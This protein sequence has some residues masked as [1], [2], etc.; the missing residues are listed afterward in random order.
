V[1]FAVVDVDEFDDIGVV[2]FTHDGDL[3]VEEIDVA[4]V[5]SLQFDDLDG[6][7][8]GFVIVP[9][10]FVDP[11]SESAA[12]E[13]LEVEAVGPHPFFALSF[14][15]YFILFIALFDVN[16]AIG[17][18]QVQKTAFLA[19]CLHFLNM[20]HSEISIIIR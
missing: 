9:D 1:V 7:P 16:R 19:T 3:V 18:R 5:H 2:E 12:D 11:A 17:A 20:F 14:C 8:N 4:N 15:E 13:V 10:A 6:V